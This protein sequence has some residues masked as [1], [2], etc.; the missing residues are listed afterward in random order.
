V[1]LQVSGR[2]PPAPPDPLAPPPPDAAEPPPPDLDPPAAL[3]AD[4]PPEPRLAGS[5][6]FPVQLTDPAKNQ[7]ALNAIVERASVE[8]RVATSA[9]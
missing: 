9:L 5:S 2:T 1:S 6:N 3:D 7:L 8:D 4:E